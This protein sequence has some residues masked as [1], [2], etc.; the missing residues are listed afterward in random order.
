MA[1]I[2]T[3]KPPVSLF[4]RALARVGSTYAT[5]AEIP[6]FAVPPALPGDLLTY[7]RTSAVVT[8]ANASNL[9]STTALVSARAIDFSFKTYTATVVAGAGDGSDTLLIAGMRGPGVP[10]GPNYRLF[11][12]TTPNAIARTTLGENMSGDSSSDWSPDGRYL[13]VT[14]IDSVA[15]VIFYDFNSGVPVL[16]NPN[17]LTRPVAA[18]RTVRFSPDGSEVAVGYRTGRVDVHAWPAG[19]APETLP[20]TLASEATGM[21]W[22]PTGRYLAVVHAAT[23]GLSIYDNDSGSWVKTSLPAVNVGSVT[24]HVSWSP[25]G[26]YMAVSHLGGARLTVYDWISGSPVKLAAPAQAAPTPLIRDRA[27][28]WSPDSRYVALA[29]QESPYIRVYDMNSGAPV[30]V[31]TLP[32]AALGGGTCCIWSPTGANLILGYQVD[33][34]EEFTNVPYLVNYAFDG[35]DFT[36]Q[37]NPTL[38]VNG[39]ARNMAWN[40]TRDLLFVSSSQFPAFNGPSLDNVRLTDALGVDHILNGSFEDTTGMTPTSY[41]FSGDVPDWT[42]TDGNGLTKTRRAYTNRKRGVIPSNGSVW[43]DM[44]GGG[45][46]DD[47]LTVPSMTLLSQ[48]VAGLTPTDSYTLAL[49]A[50]LMLRAQGKLQVFWG[51]D[52]VTFTAPDGSSVTDITPIDAREIVR[53]VPVPAGETVALP[54]GKNILRGG[55]VLQMES[56]AADCD[57]GLSYVISVQ[58]N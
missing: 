56:D 17:P 37:S 36:V 12:V 49:D 27:V 8:R 29:G 4:E 20:D 44:L 48:T 22:R 10:E 58:G 30:D 54:L 11:D 6:I 47:P 33:S 50:A 13:A 24:R 5:L 21:S 42:C 52:P 38:R 39:L 45:L 26:R 15:N 2:S 53:N 32:L 25:N 7:P 40:D 18:G 23:N 51:G 55:T 57:I 35:A 43:L 1:I 19:G 14:N 46:L 16:V 31:G 34:D 9:G 3:P 41:G 28:A